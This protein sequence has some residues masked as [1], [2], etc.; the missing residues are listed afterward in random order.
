MGHRN[1]CVSRRSAIAGTLASLA[2]AGLAGCR[3]DAWYPSDTTPDEYVLRAVIRGKERMIGRYES[4]LRARV[5]HEDLLS[6]MAGRHR[7]HLEALLAALPEG[8]EG[9]AAEAA[10]EEGGPDPVPEDPAGLPGLRVAEADAAGARI[11][12]AA[13]VED[14]G[15]AQL[16]CGIGACEAGHA[17]LLQDAARPGRGPE[18]A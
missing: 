3:G 8:S 11:H 15:L 13:A 12:Q 10:A 9:A 17:R 2:A 4:A 18:E 7:A 6:E 5:G 14:P 1:G 16:I